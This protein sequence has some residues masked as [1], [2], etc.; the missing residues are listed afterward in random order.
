[1][2]QTKQLLSSEDDKYDG[3]DGGINSVT[4]WYSD[5]LN[6]TSPTKW[7]SKKVEW[8]CG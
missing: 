7:D 4:D 6:S 8:Y 2:Q 1:M 5:A 3:V